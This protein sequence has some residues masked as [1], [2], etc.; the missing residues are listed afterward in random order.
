MTGLHSLSIHG[1]TIKNARGG[2][3]I[4][5]QTYRFQVIVEEDED[6]YYVAEVPALRACYS[7]GKTFE[8]A[9]ENVK[10]VISMCLEEIRQA[11]R[12]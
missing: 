5:M 2:E 8:E 1:I 9:V 10:E 11:R 12:N 6:G 4:S 7:Q 3:N